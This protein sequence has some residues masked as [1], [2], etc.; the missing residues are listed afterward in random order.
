MGSDVVALI[1]ARSGSKGVPDKNIR[2]LGGRPLIHWSVAAA[3]RSTRI[4]RGIV[5]TDSQTYAELALDAGAEVPFLRPVELAGDESLDR[6]FVL[7]AL[8]WLSE[9]GEEPERIVHLRPTTPFRSPQLVDEAISFFQHDQLATA[10][11]SV[12]Q[13][14]TTAYKSMEINDEGLLQQIGSLGTDLDAANGPRQGFPVTY[15]ANGYVDVLDTRLIR[16]MKL[17]HGDHVIPYVT[18]QAPEV[19]TIDDLD[20][21]E[22]HVSRYPEVF[23]QL[24]G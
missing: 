1:P 20:R 8:D 9:H 17:L 2:L 19:D 24:F 3:K 11:R 21:L 4:D 14:S 12:H 23:D 18:S 5:S 16:S 7:H 13:M 22:Y 6:E 15:L 10:L